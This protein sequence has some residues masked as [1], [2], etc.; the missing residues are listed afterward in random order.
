MKLGFIE[1]C[2]IEPVKTVISNG[3][4]AEVVGNWLRALS[5]FI[6]K[7]AVI[8]FKIS[9]CIIVIKVLQ[10]IISIIKEDGNVAEHVDKLKRYSLAAIVFY[11][12]P[13]ADQ[14]GNVLKVIFK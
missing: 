9:L 1:V 12:I 6:D 13:F 5:M 10:C 11:A 14:L 8:G 2:Y 3:I 7:V 4:S